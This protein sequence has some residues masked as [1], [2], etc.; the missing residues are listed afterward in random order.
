MDNFFTKNKQYFI[1]ALA[2]I[3]GVAIILLLFSI[4]SV[5]GGANGM[6]RAAGD[7]FSSPQSPMMDYGAIQAGAP[8]QMMAK[9]GGE[10]VAQN[11]NV[12]KKIVK[13][14]YLSLLVEKVEVSI[15]Q[16]KS[17]VDSVGGFVESSQ[18]SASDNQIY[19]APKNVGNKS[20]NIVIRVPTNIY[21]E[22]VLNIKTLAI[23]VEK[24]SGNARDVSAEYIDLDAQL[25]NLKVEESQY[26]SIMARAVK[27]DDVLNVA[28]RL[29][30]VRGRIE[31]M[32]ASLNYLGK[33]ADM[34][35]ITIDLR[36]EADIESVSKDWRPISVAKQALQ[37]MLSSLTD[38]LDGA[39]V[40][41]I[42]LPILVLRIMTWILWLLA[43]AL[44]LYL[45]W[46]L[47]K[48]LKDRYIDGK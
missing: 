26:Q 4:F 6:M 45:V 43:W 32:Q 29:S 36:S 39:I 31:R 1:Y 14:A 37:D 44:G 38:F 3:G 48:Y 5:W 27:V 46:K 35:T 42:G 47:F 18:V 10:G 22:T 12:D 34:S 28:G 15:D 40:F 21:D 17:K 24:E 8:S 30:D 11:Q 16:I 9:G 2:G 19:G 23:K 7:S 41:L 13:T 20:G 33:Q 25:K